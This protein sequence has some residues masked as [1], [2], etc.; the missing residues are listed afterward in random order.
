M[1]A[2]VICQLQTPKKTEPCP[3]CGAPDACAPFA[4]KKLPRLSDVKVSPV[5]RYSIAPD[6]NAALGGGA[7]HGAIVLVAGPGG[8]GKSTE[9]LRIASLLGTF[10]RPTI[11]AFTERDEKELAAHA[12]LCGVD[13]TTIEYARL[14]EI[15]ELWTL[16]SPGAH[17]VLDSYGNLEESVPEDFD[18]IRERIYPGTAFIVCHVI[19]SGDLEGRE[20][21]KHKASAVVWVKKKTLRTS[22]NWHGPAPI[23][24]PRA[25]P[26]LRE[27]LAPPR[28][29]ITKLAAV[30][31]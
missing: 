7:A 28:R 27:D 30:N 3:R 26:F 23:S 15:G 18:R 9:A 20:K 1:F 16:L 11:Y 24:V 29:K 17:L 21:L 14:G 25:N 22:K 5:L 13:A 2:C 10:D 19:K 4:R 6:W 8:V 12:K 31:D